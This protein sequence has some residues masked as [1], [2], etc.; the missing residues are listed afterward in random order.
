MWWVTFL[1]LLQTD[2]I[3]H[4]PVLDFL[5]TI[6]GLLCAVPRK[7]VFPF[8]LGCDLHAWGR[9]YARTEGRDMSVRQMKGGTYCWTE[10]QWKTYD[11]TWLFS[12]LYELLISTIRYGAHPKIGGTLMTATQL[13]VDNGYRKDLTMPNGRL[14]IHNNTKQFGPPHPWASEWR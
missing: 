8:L 7:N 14:V 13:G 9:A 2:S 3:F 4:H 6:I 12:I 1:F 11:G 5:W 10:S